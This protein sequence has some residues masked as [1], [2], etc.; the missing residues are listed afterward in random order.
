MT[1]TRTNQ[2]GNDVTDSDGAITG[3]D[4][5]MTMETFAFTFPTPTTENST[6]DNGATGVGNFGDAQTDE[7]HDQG[8]AFLDYGDL[9]QT[10]N[11]DAFSTQMANNGAVHVILPGFKLGVSVDGEQDGT[12]SADASGDGADEDGVTFTS[13]LIPGN[14]ATISVVSMN[15]LAQQRY[16]KAGSTGTATVCWMQRSAGLY[17][18]CDSNGQCHNDLHLP[19]PSHSNV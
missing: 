12:P 16:C 14:N 5:T 17:Q 3:M 8:F 19:G 4:L 18:Q 11:G 6:G 7:T 2:G 13:P 9:P 15:P 1:P 10:G